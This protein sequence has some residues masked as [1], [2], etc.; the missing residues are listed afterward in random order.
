M[1]LSDPVFVYEVKLRKAQQ[2]TD[3]ALLKLK[4]ALSAR[5]I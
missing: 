2:N 1:L 5:D 3:K 4:E